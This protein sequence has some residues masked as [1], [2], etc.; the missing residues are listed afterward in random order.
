M[1]TVLAGSIS[2][3]TIVDADVAALA[4]ITRTKLQKMVL[5]P[6]PLDLRTL[7]RV[8]DAPQTNLPGTPA[9]DDLGIVYGTYG[10]GATKVTTGDLKNTTT[11]RYAGFEL[12]LPENYVDA[13]QVVI[14]VRGGMDTTVASSSCTID[15]QAFLINDDGTLGSDLVATAAQSINSLTYA[16]KD[17]VLTTSSLVAGS[18]LD[19]RIT[20][21]VTDSATGT[22]VIGVLHRASLRCDIYP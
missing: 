4:N 8:W 21:T 5:Q 16:D 6:H 10:T 14:R 11:T 7:A 19:V 13:G 2:P 1:A 18:R 17:F 9:S 12:Q 22:A 20:I 15:V 3:G